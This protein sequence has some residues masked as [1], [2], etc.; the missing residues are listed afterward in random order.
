[1]EVGQ[2]QESIRACYRVLE[3]DRCHEGSYRLLMQC[4]ACLGLRARALHQY[5]M[6]EQ[7]LRQEYSTSPSPE[8][9]DLYLKVLRDESA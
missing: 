3:K 7:I 6:C 4:Y 5:K 1:M 8:T 9:R 2:H